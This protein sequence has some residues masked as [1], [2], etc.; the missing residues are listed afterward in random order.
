MFHQEASDELITMIITILLEGYFIV[1]K[2]HI[3]YVP[4]IFH[5]NDAIALR[6]LSLNLHDLDS[7]F[8][9]VYQFLYYIFAHWVGGH[10]I[11]PP[12]HCAR[13]WS[14]GLSICLD[15]GHELNI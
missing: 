1:N 2:G 5:K 3:S 14:S 8:N 11:N 9:D 10:S 13:P 12:P 7:V 4:R 15:I 6:T